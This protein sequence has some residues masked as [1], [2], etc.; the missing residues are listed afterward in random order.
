MTCPGGPDLAERGSILGQIHTISKYFRL[1]DTCSSDPPYRTPNGVQTDTS[2]SEG[3][4]ARMSSGSDVTTRWP[5]LRGMPDD[6]HI[7]DVVTT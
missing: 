7:D 5:R 3:S 1:A 6:M 2:G 4:M